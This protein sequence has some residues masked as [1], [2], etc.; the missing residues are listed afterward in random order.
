VSKVK[1]V[2]AGSAKHCTAQSSQLVAVVCSATFSMVV[3]Q[4]TSIWTNSSKIVTALQ[5]VGATSVAQ[6]ELLEVV[7]V[8]AKTAE[9]VEMLAAGGLLML[10]EAVVKVKKTLINVL[11]VP[12]VVGLIVLLRVEFDTARS[13]ELLNMDDPELMVLFTVEFDTTGSD[14]LLTMDDPELTVLFTVEFDTKRSDELLTMDDPE[15]TVWFIEEFDTTESDELLAAT[16]PGMI[17]LLKALV[18]VGASIEAVHADQSAVVILVE[19]DVT[20]S[21]ELLA[22][23]LTVMLVALA[24][25]EK[26]LGTIRPAM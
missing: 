16:I 19:F 7:V 12:A 26:L 3:L 17:V 9:S 24:E 11:F 2:Q 18:F 20:D 14:E 22:A 23:E 8:A 1:A 15:L 4:S 25:L 5:S 6:I 21:D 10:F 13:D